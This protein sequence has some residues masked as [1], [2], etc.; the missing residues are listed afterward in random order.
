LVKK[1]RENFIQKHTSTSIS[2]TDPVLNEIER[3]LKLH[4]S[5]EDVLQFW[6]SSS[7]TFHHL[8]RLAQTVLAIPVTSTPSEQVFSTTDLVVN[9]KRTMLSPHYVGKIQV[10]HDNYN[11]FK[12]IEQFVV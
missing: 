5:C 1:L 8:K 11:L 3:C 9:A 12:K 7:N 10:T 4:I 2:D 6:G